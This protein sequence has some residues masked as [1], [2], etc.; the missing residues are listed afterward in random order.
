MSR[1]AYVL[2]QEAVAGTDAVTFAGFPGIWTPG[3]PIAALELVTHGGFVDEDELADMV[4][5][6]GLPL[7]QT[8]V[9]GDDG[10][11]PTPANHV[12]GREEAIADAVE[13]TPRPRTH[14]QAD[15]LA[16]ERGIEFSREDLQ[17][18]EKVAEIF[19]DVVADEQ[20]Q[21]P[22]PPPEEEG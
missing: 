19:A 9:T 6:L 8:T 14:K 4:E 16:Q 10:A 3:E 11:M 5:E 18:D 17:L 20:P 22:E 15:K 12:A 7:E 21:P 1:A 2:P 13:E